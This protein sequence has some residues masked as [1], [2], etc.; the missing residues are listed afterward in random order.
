MPFKRLPKPWFA[1][2]LHTPDRLIMSLFNYPNR[3]N[4]PYLSKNKFNFTPVVIYIM[5]SKRKIIAEVKV[6]VKKR[7]KNTKMGENGEPSSSVPTENLTIENPLAEN[8]VKE[9]HFDDQVQVQPIIP[10][11]SSDDDL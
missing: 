1:K 3:R 9:V 6:P 8:K 4:A 7:A 11:M 10:I 5:S 2:Y